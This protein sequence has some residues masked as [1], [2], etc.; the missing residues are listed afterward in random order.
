M[1]IPFIQGD[2][3]QGN[4]QEIP[5]DAAISTNPFQPRSIFN[6]E[7][8]EELALSI[9]NYRGNPANHSKGKGRRL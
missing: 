3:D 2:R 6:Q 7:E 8:I 9:K 4:S 1:R 5:L